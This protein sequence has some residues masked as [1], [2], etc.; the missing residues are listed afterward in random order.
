M[1]QV[2]I[3]EAKTNLSAL[4]K[5]VINGEDVVISKGNKPLVKLVLLKSAKSK[6]KLGSAKGK[7]VIGA[8]FD[9]PLDDFKEYIQ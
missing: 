9:Q 5:K 6:R 1:Y 8:D 2:N 7:I 3:Q 4:I